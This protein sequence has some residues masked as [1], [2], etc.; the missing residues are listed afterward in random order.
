M[1]DFLIYFITMKL[2]NIIVILILELTLN[3]K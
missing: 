2:T 3:E 1:G